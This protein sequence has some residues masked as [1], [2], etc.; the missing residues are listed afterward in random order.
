MLKKT[1]MLILSA[2]M[3]YAGFSMGK[4]YTVVPNQKQSTFQWPKGKK[5]AISLTFDDAR[6]SQVDN[7]I[8]LLDN[9]EVTGT[10]YVLPENL[11]KRTE[12]WQNAVNKGHEI[13]NHTLYHACSENFN[14]SR[15]HSLEETTLK[16]LSKQLDSSNAIIQ[17]IL[18]VKV[19][20]FAYPCGQKY[21]GKG[22]HTK[23]YVPL[24]SKK[25]KTGRGWQDEDANDPIYC[26][27]AQLNGMVMDGKSFDEIRLLID[28]AKAKGKWL[29]LAGHEVSSGG[30]L[31]TSLITL[32]AICEY[33][34]D[35]ANGIWIDNV[36]SISSHIKKQRDAN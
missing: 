14:W 11:V 20:S 16:Q 6:L 9:Y 2:N 5:M 1:F 28:N 34:K 4:G 36:Q 12:G 25:F 10:F 22:V 23:S 19:T 29:I 32:K 24:I 27:L 7:C 26:N 18:G 31:T 21:V 35:T 13:G 15:K 3:L 17:K 30:D 33:A 8:P